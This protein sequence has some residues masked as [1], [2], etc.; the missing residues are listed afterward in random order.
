[1]ISI[2]PPRRDS[3]LFFP[4]TATV[5]RK[6]EEKL[7]RAP[8]PSKAVARE[9]EFARAPPLSM[10]AARERSSQERCHRGGVAPSLAMENP[11]QDRSICLRWWGQPSDL[12]VQAR[13]IAVSEQP[14][15]AGSIYFSPAAS[16]RPTTH[17]KLDLL[18]SAGARFLVLVVL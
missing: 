8:P 9:Q 3:P 14:P 15:L 6:V 11:W 7:A 12:V 13:A 5:M 18:G 1:M 16:H 2:T 17:R 4:A 10:G